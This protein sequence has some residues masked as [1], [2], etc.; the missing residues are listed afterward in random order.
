MPDER[1]AARSPTHP[2]QHAAAIALISCRDA[3][4]RSLKVDGG[5]G[6]EEEARNS[7]SRSNRERSR[8]RR[9]PPSTA[10]LQW[11][12][13]TAERHRQLTDERRLIHRPIV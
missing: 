12:T 11:D 7:A 3:N 6:V 1:P 13:P 8:R 9:P 10:R 4:L 2:A 5:A